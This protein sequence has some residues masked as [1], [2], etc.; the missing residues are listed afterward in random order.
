[1]EK[2]TKISYTL[3]ALYIA[4]FILSIYSEMFAVAALVLLVLFFLSLLFN[5]FMYL[6]TGKPKDVWKFGWIGFL[7]FLGFVPGLG[8]AF[9]GLYGFY[10]FF[11]FKK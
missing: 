11:G 6:R 7:G 3:L 1:M 10:G 9:F 8:V 4:A 2:Q 5:V